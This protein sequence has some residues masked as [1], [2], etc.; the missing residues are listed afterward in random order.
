MLS[1]S[2][3]LRLLAIS[4]VLLAAPAFG[5]S[6]AELKDKYEEI[7]DD[8]LENV[9][10]MPLY[11]ESSNDENLIRG[12]VYGII[13]HPFATVSKV[14]S[15]I[16]SM[17]EIVPQHLN[18]KACTYEYIN[19]QCRLTFYSGRKFYQKADDVRDINYRFTVKV[20]NDKYF[21]VTLEDEMLES[22]D[23]NVQVAAIPLTDNS[24][25]FYLSYRYQY[26]FFMHAAMSTYLATFGYNKIGFSIVGKDE[27]NQPIYV[28]GI[29]GVIER[30]IVRYYFAVKS[31]LD[32]QAV[33]LKTKQFE[34]RIS[35]WFDLTEKYH[36]QLYE[37][38]KSD[39]IKY[40]RK[41]YKDQ[42]R[43]QKVIN[44][45]R[46]VGRKISISPNIDEACIS[47]K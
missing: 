13:H 24:T 16:S 15:S 36:K 3:R 35:Y 17:C 29:S 31:Y 45:N 40:K 25:F 23:F 18:I 14:M 26:G 22:K 9:Y 42:L 34:S 10:D 28:G 8:L 38:D 4:F 19:D 21:A 43:L 37:M 7:E 32:T 33:V 12:K 39:Y 47:K 27:N 44:E 2:A 1:V 6:A 5:D 46:N 30:N 41:E 11:V 20:R